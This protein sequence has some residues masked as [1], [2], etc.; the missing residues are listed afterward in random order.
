MGNELLKIAEQ[1][2]PVYATPKV[3][4]AHFSSRA[5]QDA[6]NAASVIVRKPLVVPAQSKPTYA[7]S[8]AAWR[9]NAAGFG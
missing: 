4:Y 5:L 9:G 6:A 1:A 7:L 8:K 3:M 2:K